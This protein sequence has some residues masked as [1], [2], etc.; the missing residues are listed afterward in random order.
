MPPWDWLLAAFL[1][2]GFKVKGTARYKNE[3][4]SWIFKELQQ[5]GMGGLDSGLDQLFPTFLDQKHPSD[6]VSS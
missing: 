5:G 6:K 4:S 2:L 3:M 1:Q